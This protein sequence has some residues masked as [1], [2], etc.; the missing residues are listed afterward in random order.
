MAAPW[1]QTPRRLRAS[2]PCLP[3]VLSPGCCTSLTGF[4]GLEAARPEPP[5]LPLLTVDQ[6]N[7]PTV[8]GASSTLLL[9]D[10][11]PAGRP[12]FSHPLSI[13]LCSPKGLGFWGKSPKDPQAP[14][15]SV[16]KQRPGPNPSLNAEKEK[17]DAGGRG[18]FN[19]GSPCSARFQ[20]AQIFNT[21]V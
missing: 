9:Q 19:I 12:Q 21:T 14:S 3:G 20:Q 13:P 7:L 15:A 10:T 17:Q 5:H 1:S 16:P 4:W 8:Q 6:R 2:L 18:D 11:L